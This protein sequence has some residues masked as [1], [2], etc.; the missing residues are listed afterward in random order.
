[1]IDNSL[2]FQEQKAA[3]V[4]A[5][6]IHKANNKL[7]ILKLIKLMYLAERESLRLFGETI[8]GDAFVSM[9][10]GPVL[11][12]TYDCINGNTKHKAGG[13]N[14][15]IADKENHFVALKDPNMLRN[16]EEDLLALS[17]SDLETLD[18]TWQEFGHYGAWELRNKTHDGLCPEWEDPKGSSRPIRIEKLLKI[19]NYNEAQIKGIVNNMRDQA[20]INARLQMR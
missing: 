6:L 18:K 7:E 17:E 19:L 5:F 16:P 1:M 2:L 10:H 8:T 14:D 9:P 13:W 11:S 15:W 3:Q 20:E 4:A 12:M